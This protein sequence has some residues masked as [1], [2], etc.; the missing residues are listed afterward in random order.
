MTMPN[1]ESDFANSPAGKLEHLIGFDAARPAKMTKELFREILTEITDERAKVTKVKAKELLTKA[2][3][4]RE[5]AAKAQKEYLRA[6]AA[7]D[8]EL[9]KVI[10]G[11]N[12][13][14]EGRNPNAE[15]N[16]PKAE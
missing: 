16:E 8:K 7:F 11:I 2:I 13:M 4:I 6:S 1:N 14:L 15:E 10:N 3:T 5:S 9:G 12:A